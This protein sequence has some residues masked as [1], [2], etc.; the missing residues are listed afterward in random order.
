[1]TERT[2][3][4]TPLLFNRIAGAPRLAFHIYCRGGNQHDQIPGQLDLIDRL[5]TKGTSTRSAEQIAVAIDSLSLE[6]DVDTRRDYSVVMGTVLEEDLEASFELLADL[7]HHSNLLELPREAA[8]LQ[9]EITMDLDSPRSKASDLLMGAVFG[10]TSYATVGSRILSQLDSL[11]GDVDGLKQHYQAIYQPSNYLISVAGDIELSR[12][13]KAL[14][15]LLESPNLQAVP[16]IDTAIYSTIAIP[17]DIVVTEAKGDTNQMNLFRAWLAPKALDD[18]GLAFT[19]LN[20][21][22]GSGG[23]SSRLFVELRDKQGLAYHVR[24]SLEHYQHAGLFSLYIGTE[25]SNTEKCLKGFQEEV[26]KLINIPVP[27]D[28]LAD[29]KANLLGR[30]SVFLETALQQ[31]AYI[32]SNVAQ[33]RNLDELQRLPERIA[34]ITANDIQRIASTYLTKP[35]VISAV[36]PSDH[37]PSA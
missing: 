2:L 18:D 36:G 7:L 13:E 33:G 20:T 11:S 14:Q 34:A 6:L 25:P 27:A 19:V 5:L 24:S 26:D 37:L 29:A 10:K 4:K 1:M 31:S 32:G 15:P 16:D 30:R 17:K 21:I 12:V 22:L 35:S 28:E 8:K 23:L 9:G 3:G